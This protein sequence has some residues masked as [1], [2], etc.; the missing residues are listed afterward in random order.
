MAT[1]WCIVTFFIPKGDLSSLGSILQ[2]YIFAADASAPQNLWGPSTHDIWF[3]MAFDLH[4]YPSPCPILSLSALL[5]DLSKNWTPFVATPKKE[6]KEISFFELSNG[7]A[8]NLAQLTSPQPS[9]SLTY[10]DER[11]IFLKK[12]E[13]SYFGI[14]VNLC[15]TCNS[16]QET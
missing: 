5:Y 7:L 1:A 4:R 9:W 6:K 13:S 12:T 10:C 2:S 11:S 16:S 14:S 8:L 15:F 3:K